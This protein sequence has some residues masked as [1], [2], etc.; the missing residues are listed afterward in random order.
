[1][2]G[3]DGEE[4]GK[5]AEPSQAYEKDLSTIDEAM[6]PIDLMQSHDEFINAVKSRLTKLEGTNLAYLCMIDYTYEEALLSLAPAVYAAVPARLRNHRTVA[7]AMTDR[8]WIQDIQFGV[9]YSSDPRVF[10]ALGL[11]SVSAAFRRAGLSILAVGDLGRIL[12]PLGLL[13]SL[14]WKN[15][16]P[17]QANLAIFGAPSLSLLPLVETIDHLLVACPESRQ[18]WWVALRAIG[19][20]ECLPINEHSFL[21][22]LCDCRKRM[23]KEH[24]RGFD[25][26]ATLV[27]WTIWKERNNRVFNQKSRSWAEVVRV[28]TG[29]AELWRLAR[30]AI[31]ALV[32]H[33]MRHVFDQNGIKGA[34]AA[35]AKLPD[36]A[37]QADVVSTLKRKLDLFSLDIFLSFLPVLAGLLT[38]K[39]ERHAIVSLELLLDLIKIFGPVIRS[40]LSAHSAVGVDIQAEQR[41]GGQSAQLAQELN[42]SLHDLV[43]HS[44]ILVANQFWLAMVLLSY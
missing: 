31:P 12:F 9:G 5:I 27:A 32:A 37:V 4:A 15:S 38:S 36:N 30:A 22:W 20:S 28:M 8:R 33:M 10:Q 25:T 23:V 40:T 13:C 7:E 17:A 34:I 18:L 14:F 44:A 24:R 21:S 29:E 41:R 26:I 43:L 39:A 19:H 11:P 2:A 16:S 3:G 42:L 35:V 1:M 6:I